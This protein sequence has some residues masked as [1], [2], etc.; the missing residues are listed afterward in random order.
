MVYQGLWNYGKGRIPFV[1]YSKGE[2]PA[3]SPFS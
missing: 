2:D 1:L 3:V